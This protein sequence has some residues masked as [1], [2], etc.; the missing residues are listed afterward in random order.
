[1]I[2]APE[3]TVYPESEGRRCRG[4]ILQ[5][6]NLL[7]MARFN[8]P[9]LMASP[10][11]SD[12]RRLGAVHINVVYLSRMEVEWLTVMTHLADSVSGY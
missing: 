2:L 5:A 6:V 12:N 8:H 1:M 11:S 7:V 4:P 3:H 10:A 9:R